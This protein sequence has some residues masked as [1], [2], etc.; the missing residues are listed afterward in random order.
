MW[1]DITNYFINFFHYMYIPHGAP[2]YQGNIWGNAFV[3]AVIAPLGYIWSK[4]E[5]FP[6]KP[7]QHG[8]KH[9]HDK[10][11]GLHARHDAHDEI[12]AKIVASLE[13]LHEKHDVLYNSLHKRL[14]HR[15][16]VLKEVKESLSPPM[17]PLPSG[18][19]TDQLPLDQN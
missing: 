7:I 11:D 5:S 12:Q 2:F 17:P 8:L 18:S 10:V 9:L 13:L 1:H 6:L 14:D 3:I 19:H 16:N 15:D 4:T